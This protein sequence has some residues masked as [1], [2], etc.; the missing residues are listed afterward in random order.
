[1]RYRS[2]AA[3]FALS[4]VL[5]PTFPTPPVFADGAAARHP[6][7]ERFV[8]RYGERVQGFAPSA[9]PLED[10]DAF[11][12][13]YTAWQTERLNEALTLSKS[14]GSAYEQTPDADLLIFAEMRL[15][16]LQDSVDGYLRSNSKLAHADARMF[17]RV[18]QVLWQHL[19]MMRSIHKESVERGSDAARKMLADFSADSGW[20]KVSA[21]APAPTGVDAAPRLLPEL[22]LLRGMHVDWQARLFRMKPRV[23]DLLPYASN[24][25]VPERLSG[26]PEAGIRLLPEEDIA[27]AAAA[28]WRGSAISWAR[29]VDWRLLTVL[30]AAGAAAAWLMTFFAPPASLAFWERHLSLAVSGLSVAYWLLPKSPQSDST[31]YRR[32]V[33]LLLL[34]SATIGASAIALTHGWLPSFVTAAHAHAHTIAHRMNLG[35][36]DLFFPLAG[37]GAVIAAFVY[38]TRPNAE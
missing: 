19:E 8:E 22:D 27:T 20:D 26:M 5:S 4:V 24:A 37:L 12:E 30:L 13:E 15:M 23:A 36:S 14:I 1:M 17:L 11:V 6:A 7:I 25:Y 34:M 33:G 38:F 21:L 3:A 10:H 2:L 18:D 29:D 16:Q 28:D 35:W 32:K 9:S 31:A